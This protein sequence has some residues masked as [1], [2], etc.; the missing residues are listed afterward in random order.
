[1]T[2]VVRTNFDTYWGNDISGF[3]VN[4]ELTNTS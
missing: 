4:W 3:Y 2:D 1:M